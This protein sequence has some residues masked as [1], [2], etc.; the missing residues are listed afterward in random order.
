MSLKRFVIS[1]LIITL[2]CFGAS[3]ELYSQQSLYPVEVKVSP[4]AWRYFSKLDKDPL[5]T[6]IKKNLEE[7]FNKAISAYEKNKSKI[8]NKNANQNVQCIINAMDQLVNDI[9]TYDVAIVDGIPIPYKFKKLI[10]VTFFIDG[11]FGSKLSLKSLTVS[12]FPGDKDMRGGTDSDKNIYIFNAYTDFTLQRIKAVMQKPNNKKCEYRHVFP[13][14]KIPTGARLSAPWKRDGT[15][16]FSLAS[17]M[18]HELIHIALKASGGRYD[19]EA[20][21]EDIMLKIFPSS[22]NGFNAYEYQFEYD[23]FYL[24]EQSVN[25]FRFKS[26]GISRIFNPQDDLLYDTGGHT[27]GGNYTYKDGTLADD[28]RCEPMKNY[29][30]PK[31]CCK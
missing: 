6:K 13:F 31:K 1:I 29:I 2:F 26:G 7:A 4:M 9:K 28:A 30:I 23:L 14:W 8:K 21:V 22:N 5:Y 18:L 17:A 24:Q 12:S 10:K 19:D 3:R 15:P 20:T 25:Q 16:K 27:L 11:Q